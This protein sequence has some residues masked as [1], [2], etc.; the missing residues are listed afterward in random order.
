MKYMW[1]VVVVLCLTATGVWAQS[2]LVTARATG[3]GGA[4]IG[5]ADDAAAWFQNPAGLAALHVPVQEGKIWGTDAVGTLASLDVGPSTRDAWGVN[6]S[7]WQPAEGIGLGGGFSHTNDVGDVI[8]A[9]FGTAVK[10]MPLTGGISLVHMNPATGDS[11][12]LVNLGGMWRFEQPERGPI[13]LGVTVEDIFDDIGNGATLNA[14]V[15]WPVTNELLFAA[16]ATDLTGRMA[17][18]PFFNAGAELKPVSVAGLALRAGVTDTGDKHA[19]T[20][21]AG[22]VVRNWRFDAAFAD[23]EDGLWSFSAG[24]HF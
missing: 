24:V 7:G 6:V 16:D 21:G 15:A 8:G 5:V 13:R 3:M 1:A 20:A 17:D 12:T 4:G 22:Y 2:G 14:G 19:F 11:S 18:G 9:G 23:L 10:R